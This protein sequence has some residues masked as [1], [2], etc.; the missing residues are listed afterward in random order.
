MKKFDIRDKIGY[1]FGDFG[2]DFFFI[3]IAS[4]LMLFYT[5]VVGIKPALVGVIFLAARIWDAFADVLWGRFIDSR[6][7]TRHGKF[8]PWILRMF[9]PLIVFGVLT[10]TYIPGWNATMNTIYCF[11]T[12][13]IWGT[14]YSMVNIPYGSMASVITR[15][16]VERSSLST[17]RS[18]GAALV[19]VTVSFVVPMVVFVNRKADGSRFMIV[20]IAFAAGAAI[21]Y[22]LCYFMTTERIQAP[23]GTKQKLDLKVTVKGVAKNRPLLA[24]IAAA[25]VLLLSS[26]LGSG[27]NSYL[28]KDYF[29][30]TQALTLA[31]V[32]SVGCTLLVAP[33]I[34][35]I[36][37]KT[38][39]KEA[40]AIA[41]LL[42]AVMYLLM[43]LLPIHNAW[44][45][46]GL[47]FIAGLGVGFFM[48]VIWAFIT[49]VI[50]Y[51][52]Y[53]TGMREDGTIYSFYSFARKIGQALAGG[54]SGFALASIGYIATPKG[55]P[56]VVQTLEVANGIKTIATLVPAICYFVVFLI[57]QFWY[58]LTKAKLA[59][60][61][62]NLAKKRAASPIK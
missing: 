27:M 50:D 52:E 16:P 55:Q 28:F 23:V 3:F 22:L 26:L 59:E 9:I 53:L 51:Q 45:F 4:F 19:G 42:S 8:R 58:P 5:D 35:T 21:S 6:P 54:L 14:L 44:L 39:K 41:I 43:Y 10:F 57:L 32:V 36:T 25:L 20:A 29:R 1:M 24:I 30:N 38:G 15:D 31:G 56:A 47:M 13:L 40:S 61:Q 7:T 34:G 18:I 2:N 37:Q 60:M 33:F 11:A 46:I 49:D 12:Y 17:F 48:A 62:K